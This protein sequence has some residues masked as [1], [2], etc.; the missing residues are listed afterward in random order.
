MK[1]KKKKKDGPNQQQAQ[2]LNKMERG[3]GYRKLFQICQH[4]KMSDS[5]RQL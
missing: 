5:L 2:T 3:T 1:K 4:F